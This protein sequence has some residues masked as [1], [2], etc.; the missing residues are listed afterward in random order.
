MS[1]T[2]RVLRL[3]LIPALLIGCAESP[4]PKSVSQ[5]LPA[6]QPALP[7]GRV[8]EAAIG[9]ASQDVGSLPVNMIAS[10]DGKYVITTDTGFRES[11]WA[12][13]T[14]DGKGTGHVDYPHEKVKR[15]AGAAADPPVDSTNGLYFGL[16]IGADHTL[17]ASQ[18]AHDSIAVLKLGGDGGLTPVRAIATGKHDFPAGL[19]L[20]GR[21]Y[22]F[23]AN[24][25][26]IPAS[27]PSFDLPASVAAYEA[28]TGKALGRYRFTTSFGGTS[29]FPLAVAA[30]KDGS[31]AYVSSERD[32]AVYVLNATKPDAMELRATLHTGAHP[33]ALL[34]DKSQSR[35]FVSNASSDTISIVDTGTD[36]VI[37]TV[38]LRPEIAKELPGATPLG[39][40][41]SPDEKTLYVA[42]ADMNAVGVIDLSGAAPAL[43]GYM[44]AGWYPSAVAV[45]PDGKRLLVANAKGTDSRHPKSAAGKRNASPL[46][47][48]EGNV[49]LLDAPEAEDLP[50]LTARVLAEC[51]LTPVHL[52]AGNPLAAINLQAGKI[53]H[54]IYIVKE[55]RTYDQ[56][57]GDLPQG[58][59]DKAYAIFGREVTPNLHALAERFVLL[60]NFYDSGEVSGDGWVWSTQ[61]YANEYV[62]RNVPYMYSGRGRKFDFEGTNN[63][64]PTGGIPATAPTGERLSRDPRFAAG[65]KPIPDVAASP[66]G[67]L[68]DVARA[69]GL[70]VRN[71]GM[72]CCNGVKQSGAVIIPDNYP[73][74]PGLQP[75]GHDLAGITDLDFRRFDLDYPDS[76]A[77]DAFAKQTGDKAF[78]R[79]HHAF[80]KNEA[81]ARITEWKREFAMML[82]KDPSGAA[83]PNL[84]LVR[85]GTDHTF[86]MSGGK[87]TPRSMVADNDYAVG[88]LVE[89]VS[90]SA[91]WKNTAIVILEDDAQNGPDHVD[92]HRSICLVISPW[93]KAHSADHSFQNTVSAIRTMELL[94]GLPPMNQYDAA[95]DPIQGWSSVPENAEPYIALMA[96][97]KLIREANPILNPVKPVSPEL[98][99]AAAPPAPMP[100]AIRKMVAE[101]EKMD[102]AHADA[103]PAEP[104]NR[105]IWAS[106]KGPDI[107]MPP[108]PHGP[109]SSKHAQGKHDDD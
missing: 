66:G 63:E 10:P 82:K 70:S 50:D 47:L 95:A 91:I 65:V 6:T 40:A 25:D 49:V 22:L 17:Y 83:V 60:D 5:Q 46:N 92:A 108:T 56:V 11:L 75:G 13:S 14:A 72:F 105:M 2:P 34:L 54:V 88:Q 15:A 4:T 35:L 36:Q 33:A 90:H 51:R 87:H 52:R 89:T 32:D 109:A 81:P 45:S 1:F 79:E 31:K 12:I 69:A 85:L 103:A 107:P 68:W 38:L 43:K 106:V 30:L 74:A 59:G 104:L 96:D 94:L 100:E 71:Y 93:I 58:N 9:R 73:N 101:A 28:S 18:G 8:I 37:G 53:T 41:L 64:Y 24:N 61:A 84:M 16:A 55:N 19:A 102:F 97:Q 86:G 20:D 29:N 7:T 98:I 44:P 78:L 3:F 99:P 67:H 48:L 21:G 27:G 23:A 77:P 57:L 80:G 26:P 76:E 62:Q 42:I 39:L